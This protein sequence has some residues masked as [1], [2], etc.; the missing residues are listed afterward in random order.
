MQNKIFYIVWNVSKSLNYQIVFLTVLM[1]TFVI[2]NF[3]TN[4]LQ[5][6]HEWRLG[7]FCSFLNNSVKY[8][9]ILLAGAQT[10]LKPLMILNVFLNH[11]RCRTISKIKLYFEQ[12][13]KN[14][15]R[16][17]WIKIIITAK[18]FTSFKKIIKHLD[19]VLRGPSDF[20]SNWNWKWYLLSREEN[21]KKNF[22]ARTTYK[23]YWHIPVYH[24]VLDYDLMNICDELL[25]LSPH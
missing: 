13:L 14:V 5:Y 23:W 12:N 18:W 21:R 15:N 1:V 19:L 2:S 25:R 11:I 10:S 9:F 6:R 16:I 20:R 24:G 8:S 17:R 7:K 4:K 3:W 22:G